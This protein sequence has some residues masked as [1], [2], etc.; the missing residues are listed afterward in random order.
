MN[1]AR[2]LLSGCIDYAGLF[3]PAGLDLAST[4][5]EYGRYH[6][7]ADAW[8]LGPLVLPVGSLAGFRSRRPVG[9]EHW[10]LSLLLG[11]EWKND[12]RFAEQ[13]GIPLR[14]IE[15]KPAEIGQIAAVR[16]ALPPEARIYFEVCAGALAP[17]Y[18]AAVA[19]EGACAKIRTGGVKQEAIPEAPEIARLLD[20]CM[21]RGVAFKATAGLHH[22]LRGIHPLTYEPHSDRA[23]MHGFV[24]VILA[25][26]MIYA[27]GDLKQAVALLE[28]DSRANFAIEEDA[29]RWCGE[30]FSA[31]ALGDTREHFML[32]FGS[33][34]FTEPLAELRQMRWL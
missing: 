24:N 9:A 15:F 21:R 16:R 17:E 27:G 14:T 22:A 3:P 33:C 19:E 30:S 34:S 11:P 26:A 18:L 1:A 4:M 23:P 31:K 2:A 12:I 32:S 5:N 20:C 25:A 28:D 7:G 29:V 10:P 13:L 8:A 6:D